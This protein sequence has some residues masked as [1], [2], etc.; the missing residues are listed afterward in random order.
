MR[1]ATRS[2]IRVE[3]FDL[4]KAAVKLLALAL[5]RGAV[6]HHSPNEC[7]RREQAKW[8]RALAVIYGFP[9]LAIFWQGRAY[10]IE[11]KGGGTPASDNQI[12]AAAMLRGAGCPVKFCRSLREIVAALHEFG[13]PCAVS[14]GA[15]A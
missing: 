10:L 3:E 5:P 8:M 7:I 12:D 13:I 14:L 4:H 15:I 9:D 2:A 11:L 1:R 6:V